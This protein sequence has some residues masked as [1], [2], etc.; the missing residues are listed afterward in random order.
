MKRKFF[1]RFLFILLVAGAGIVNAQSVSSDFSWTTST[2]NNTSTGQIIGCNGGVVDV[3]MTSSRL[4]HILESGGTGAY[5]PA[6]HLV[7]GNVT[8]TLTFSPAVYDLSILMN[9]FDE[10]APG[11]SDDGT[12]SEFGSGFSPPFTSITPVPGAQTFVATGFGTG[13]DPAGS[14][15]TQGWVNWTG[16]ISTVTFTYE[17][18]DAI[19]L[20]G[21][22]LILDALEFT[23]Q[24]STSCVCSESN[25]FINIGNVLQNGQTSSDIKI[26]SGGVA[27][28]TLNISVPFWESL[29]DPSCLDCNDN[30]LLNSG[31]II[32][33][34]TIAGVTPTFIGS[35]G[36]AS[37]IVYQFST[38]TLINDD[39]NISMQFPPV[40]D[41]S[42]CDNDVD[43]CIKIQ[44]ITEECEICET[45][46][47][48]SDNGVKSTELV[49][50][51][52]EYETST[53]VDSQIET[54]IITISPNPASDFINIELPE[55]AGIVYVYSNSGELVSQLDVNSKNIRLNIKPYNTGGY[56]VKYIYRNKVTISK[57]IIE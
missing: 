41:L 7:A 40:L 48:T 33:L 13:V 12:P 16:L 57:L 39:V 15:N 54:H 22:G 29:I 26:N 35:G 34:P 21:W 23:C 9:D 3:T 30:A 52:T 45:I 55:A 47:C 11:G 10:Y 50:R 37:E 36:F 19:N 56:I 49:N 31:K 46:I 18:P 5:F 53:N 28:S 42:C 25:A 24:P 43:Y 14:T 6:D 4:P 38:P 27:I 44:M 51:K 20:G 8:I 32:N 2:S 17:R 1:K